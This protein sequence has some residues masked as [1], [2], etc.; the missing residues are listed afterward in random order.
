MAVRTVKRTLKEVENVTSVDTVD[1]VTEVANVTS[2]DTVDTV[3][4]V[5]EVTSAIITSPLD[6]TFNA[7]VVIDVEH[8]EAHEGDLYGKHVTDEDFDTADEL[9]ICFTTPNTAKRVHVTMD[10]RAALQRG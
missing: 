1:A 9:N 8:H 10:Y 4:V 5:D 3:T 2:V 7:I 6:G